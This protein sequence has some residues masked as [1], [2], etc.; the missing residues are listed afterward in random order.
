MKVAV[1]GGSFDPFHQGHLEVI[2]EAIKT[3]D[4]DKLFVIPTFL[5]PFKESFML[6]EEVRYEKV[7]EAL[8]GFEK[9][10]VLDYEIE[11]KRKVP[12]YETI[13]F[14]KTKY[15]LD[16]I[17]LIVGADNLK[18]LKK[19][20][21]YEKL[22]ELV[23]FII[24]KRDNIKIS[25]GFKVLNVDIDISSTKI[26]RKM[27]VEKIV[28]LLD[29]K[30]AENIQVFDMRE[31]DYFVDEVI[32]ATILNDKHGYALV[33]YLKPL[34]KELGEKYIHTEESDDWLVVDLGD[35]L[36]HLMS[37]DYR[38]RYNLEEFLLEIGK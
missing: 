4:I 3:L 16:K 2:K 22:K 19:W 27:R 18:S 14:L 36:I 10:K 1:F 24:A 5:N 12:T 7:K 30:K 26:R 29:E 35:M 15:D 8:K 23:E 20:Y 21:R 31:S 6:N 9:V 11:Q 28:N 37:S 25:E 34:L 33:D 38:T 13:L 17:Y 32:I